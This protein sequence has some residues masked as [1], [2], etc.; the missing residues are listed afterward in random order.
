M[1]KSSNPTYRSMR[2]VNTHKKGILEITTRTS[3][4]GNNAAEV[5]TWET[6]KHKTYFLFF[7]A[8]GP[9]RI[10]SRRQRRLTAHGH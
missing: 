1:K 6:K 2:Q 9:D 4:L 3:R 7:E 8:G 5:P 10:R